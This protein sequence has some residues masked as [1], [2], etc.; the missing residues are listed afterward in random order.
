M[1]NTQPKDASGTAHLERAQTTASINS[2]DTGA[3]KE[4]F[5]IETDM[6]AAEA[7]A[8]EFAANWVDGTLE[9]K[10]LIR[11]LDWRILPCCWILYLLGFLDRANIGYEFTFLVGLYQGK[12]ANTMHRNAKTGGLERDF[13]L[14]SSQY[15]IIV[16]VFFVSYLCF[17]VPANM[18][19]TRVRPSVF[20]PGLGLFWGTIA[21][22]MGATQ[23]WQQLAGM[24]FLLGFAEV[25]HHCLLCLRT[26]IN[27]KLGGLPSW[28]RILSQFMV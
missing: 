5:H 23:N 6:A 10:R 13:G 20:L 1:S 25:G 26:L 3:K 14:T 17:E 4:N 2:T 19:L 21:A 18:I 12:V 9:E 22:L 15:S 24:R 11:K 8:R 7:E 27:I 16:L 28:M